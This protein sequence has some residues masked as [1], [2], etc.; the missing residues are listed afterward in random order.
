MHIQLN[1]GILAR[2]AGTV[3]EGFVHVNLYQP[4]FPC[5]NL[6]I[7]LYGYED[8]FYKYQK[9]TGSGKNRRKKT[10]TAHRSQRI[11]KLEYPMMQ[12]VDGP[13]RPG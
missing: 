3:I 4:L 1:D 7:G 6:T 11:I 2:S 13:P 5:K 9:S 12:C 8:V 10:V